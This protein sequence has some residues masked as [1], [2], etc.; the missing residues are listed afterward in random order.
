MHE[1]EVSA[2]WLIATMFAL[3]R[4]NAVAVSASI[5]GLSALGI[6]S[7]LYNPEALTSL[8]LSIASAVAQFIVVRAALER[9]GLV[10]RSGRAVGAYIG[11]SILTNIGIILGLILLVIPGLV[12]AIRW[13]I[14][15]PIVLA[16]EQGAG[17]SM[18]ESW[19]RTK[20]HAVPVLIAYL[21]PLGL[22]IGSLGIYAIG[23]PEAAQIPLMTSI[24]GNLCGNAFS[25][26]TW[27][28]S[29]AIYSVLTPR[30]DPLEEIFA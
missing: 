25:V 8:P 13:S 19:A 26:M 18:S 6:A 9:P 30:T 7:D 29:V 23:D 12:L 20:G 10:R 21:V 2:G 22:L 11:M 4:D 5:L 14:A 16:E 3:M 24:A 27:L 1:D 28:L 17:D 15:V